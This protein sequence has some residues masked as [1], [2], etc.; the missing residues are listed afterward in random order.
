MIGRYFCEKSIGR[1][2]MAEVWKAWD[3][4]LGRFT[5]LKFLLFKEDRD[6]EFFQREARLVANL[7]HPHIAPIY[8]VGTLEGQPYISMMLIDGKT[9]EGCEFNSRQGAEYV[10]DACRGVA[11]AHERG[12][13]HRDLKPANIMRSKEGQIYVTDFGLARRVACPSPHSVSG[14]LIGT[15][16]YMAPEQIRGAE[17]DFRSD[18][19]ALG[20]TLKELV[21]NPSI[22]LSSIISKCMSEHPIDRYRNASELSRAL[23][24]YLNKP[25]YLLGGIVASIAILGVLWG[26]WHGDRLIEAGKYRRQA[27]ARMAVDDTE[28]AVAEFTKALAVRP[29]RSTYL[30]RG[31]CYYQLGKYQE[32]LADCEAALKLDPSS[33]AAKKDRARC[34]LYVNR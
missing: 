2:G 10:R 29:D 16:C 17:A 33:E 23:D 34:L 25:K 26:I 4:K 24:S 12:I 8:D 21:P 32:A 3:T 11:F 31:F 22:R 30:D 15:P 27:E 14:S 28:G 6:L 7:S 1:G 20:A 19:Y 9:L 5:A 18:V 13:V